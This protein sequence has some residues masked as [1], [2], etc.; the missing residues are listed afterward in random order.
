MKSRISH[1]LFSLIVILG[2]N[3]SGAK[4]QVILNCE[5][6]NRAVEQGSCW[7]FGST[8]YTNTAAQVITGNWSTRSN[9]L[10]NPAPTACWIKTPWMQMGSGNITFNARF[11]STA[12][13]TRGIELYY[14]AYDPTDP[15]YYE[16]EP[17]QFY[18]YNWPKPW[19]T[20]VAQQFAVP[21]PAEIANSSDPFKIRVSY[22]G[23][24]GTARINSD[25]FV[26]PG[27][28]YSDP[29][30]GCLPLAGSVDTDGD[31]VA[32]TDDDYPQDP[33]RAYNTFYPSAVSYGTV[34]FEDNWPA[35]GDYDLN[36]VVVDYRIKHVANAQNQLVES[37]VQL[38]MKAS[39]ASF[40]NGFGFSL[41]GIASN[42]VV[43][44]SGH[45]VAANSIFNL[46]SNGLEQ[47]QTNA[48]VI[49]FDNF[50]RLMPYPGSGV[51]INT[52]PG[53]P[54]VASHDLTITLTYMVNGVPA[55][56]GAVSSNQLPFTSFNFFIVAKQTRGREIHL[57]GYQPTN[58]VDASYFGQDDDDTQPSVGKYYKTVNNL[59]W[60]INVLQ[61]FDYP[62]ELAPVNQAYL[63]FIEWAESGGTNYPD[64]YGSGAGYR[65]NS[66]IY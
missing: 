40:R 33:Y 46:T 12:G 29:T 25:D 59:P 60:G 51:G 19:S 13:T 28:Y 34:A 35:K 42:R 52:T 50:Y 2:L 47:G 45:D 55:S 39:G 20:T 58:L 14:I 6:G 11:E 17:V 31:G 56:G 64:W 66:K 62:V 53:A 43:S 22:V 57:P 44:C 27:A 54:S 21:I 49:A 61:G 1:S 37:V 10:T 16:A 48:T 4:G 65:D 24:G 32:D 9:Q 30:N 38:I 26:F 8:S 41:D 23:T 7:A 18:T 15:P 3:H 36:D 63:H 5:S